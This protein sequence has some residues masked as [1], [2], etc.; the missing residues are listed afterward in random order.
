MLGGFKDAG[1]TVG[2]VVWDVQFPGVGRVEFAN[3]YWGS[4]VAVVDGDWIHGDHLVL[5]E[6]RSRRWSRPRCP[7]AR[8]TGLGSLR[9]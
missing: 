5:M 8:R 3:G 7:V 4:R 1:K 2:N 9:R 6:V